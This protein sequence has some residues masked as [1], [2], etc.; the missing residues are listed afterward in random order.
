MKIALPTVE[1]QLCAH[2]GHCQQFCIIE[3][4]SKN[5]ITNKQML[6]P[7]KHEPGVLPRW[8]AEQG[9]ELVLA[10]GMGIRAQNLFE[11]KNIKVKTGVDCSISLED[12]VTSYLSNTLV[13][14]DNTCSH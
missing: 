10:G 3:T 4:D 11:E 2:F 12:A 9:V 1:G 6:T 5:N 14:G 8:L 13:T 7:P